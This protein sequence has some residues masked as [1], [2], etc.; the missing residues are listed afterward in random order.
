MAS[1]SEDFTL[2]PNNSYYMS[3]YLPCVECTTMNLSDAIPTRQVRQ[4]SSSSTEQFDLA[5]GVWLPGVICVLGILGNIISLVVLSCDRS[6][7]PTFYSLKA[8][9]ST[10]VLLL[11]SALVQQVVPMFCFLIKCTNSFCLNLGYV[12]V[13]VWPVICIAQMS[14]IW[15][16]VLIS[17]ER[18]AAICRPLQAKSMRN[19]PKVRMGVICI[20]L[21][22]LLFNMPKFFEF[23]PVKETS[24]VTNL[25][26]VMVGDTSLRRNPVYR[27]LY[28]TA[29]YCLVI[30]AAP[31]SILTALNVKI[32][33]QMRQA[34]RVWEQ[35]NRIQQRELKATAIPLCIVIVFFVCGTQS[36]VSFILDA[37]FVESTSERLQIYT[38]VVNL[39][40]IINSAINFLIFYLFGSKFRRLLRH[41]M[42][43]KMNSALSSMHD[44]PILR[45]RFR[46]GNSGQCSCN[47]VKAQSF[48]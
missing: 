34:S 38:A 10:D 12:R 45:R 2:L 1:Q 23:Q 36:L 8:L 13:Y 24:T 48:L 21:L 41:V 6:K 43:C 18:Y 26:W 29:L 4:S 30:Y 22:S 5:M 16:T 32:V 31:L 40:V 39:L 25:T 33:T 7:C 46:G 28:N 35:L 44:S 19:L 27:Y 14:S 47:G 3:S 37:V 17:A 42:I 11:T 20:L 15:L 9:A